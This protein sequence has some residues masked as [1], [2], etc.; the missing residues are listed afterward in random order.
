MVNWIVRKGTPADASEIADL[1]NRAYRGQG[2]NGSAQGWTNE[3]GLVEGPR[4]SAAEIL[5]HMQEGTFLCARETEPGP[6][7]GSVWLE[8]REGEYYIGML[9]VLPELQNAGLGR[10]LMRQCE[11]LA[12]GAGVPRLTLTVLSPRAELQAWYERQGYQRTGE[13]LPF[14]HGGPHQL[15]VFRKN[16][17]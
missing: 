4:T 5:Q 16:A 10:L 6:L 9:S 2:E 13:T 7:Q 12:R 11:A 17:T 15:F 1:V 14:P 3:I 8:S